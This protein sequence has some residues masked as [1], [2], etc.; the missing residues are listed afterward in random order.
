MDCATLAVLKPA[1]P[2]FAGIAVVFGWR[3]ADSAAK[4]YQ[5]FATRNDAFENRHDPI[6]RR[7]PALPLGKSSRPRSGGRGDAGRIVGAAEAAV[8]AQPCEHLSARRRR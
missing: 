8:P 7:G 6:L 5:T 3:R 4:P 2:C 1:S